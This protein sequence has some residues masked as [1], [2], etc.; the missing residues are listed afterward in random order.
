M[1]ESYGLG[2]RFAWSGI[3][4]FGRGGIAFVVFLL[5]A[6][7]SSEEQLATYGVIYFFWNLIY[8]TSQNLVVQPLIE[9]NEVN[10]KQIFSATVN[11]LVVS[12]FFSA[13]LLSTATHIQ[14]IYPEQL[15]IEVYIGYL[16][17]LTPLSTI[18][19]AH[20]V[21]K[22]RDGDF[23]SI[24]LYQS[25]ASAAAALTGYLLS[26]HDQYWDAY[27]TNC[28]WSLFSFFFVC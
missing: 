16:M 23:K 10:E 12:A 18:G 2:S 13:I 20:F 14:K 27:S 26:L 15:G 8:I 1:A 5:L 21:A 6:R 28:S 11:A 17:V 22:Q 4:L 24:A 3:A 25:L 7:A 9:M 19:L